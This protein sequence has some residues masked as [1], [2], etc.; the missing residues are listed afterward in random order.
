MIDNGIYIIIDYFSQIDGAPML[1]IIQVKN[2]NQSTIN[3]PNYIKVLR[4][5]TDEP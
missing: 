2:E 5:V 4:E 3:L 1:G